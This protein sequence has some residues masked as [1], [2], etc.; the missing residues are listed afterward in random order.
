M[1]D[2]TGHDTVRA[3]KSPLAELLWYAGGLLPLAVVCLFWASMGDQPVLPQRIVLLVVG[4]V[5]GG[6]GL[7]AIG[8]LIRPTI[9]AQAQTPNSGSMAV[10]ITMGPINNNQGIITQGQRRVAE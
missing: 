4:A 9:T 3:E 7:L 8:E 1:E 5:I 2:R 6:C 10:P